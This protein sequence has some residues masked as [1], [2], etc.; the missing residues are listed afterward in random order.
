MSYIQNEIYRM[1]K[2][3]IILIVTVLH[4]IFCNTCLTQPL[5]EQI[6]SNTTNNLYRVLFVSENVGWIVGGNGTVL[7]TTNGTTW[8]NV[9]HLFSNVGDLRGQEVHFIDSQTGFISFTGI[10]SKL[11]KTG[12]K[13]GLFYGILHGEYLEWHS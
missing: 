11:F 8:Q 9:S 1:K 6:E 12:G 3:Y 5:W 4:C 10:G 13:T 2:L 7:K